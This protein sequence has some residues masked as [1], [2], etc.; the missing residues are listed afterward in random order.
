LGE[1]T[2]VR[3]RRNSVVIDASP[4]GPAWLVLADANYPGWTAT[5]D[6]V[7]AE[8]YMVDHILRG[9]PL[10]AGRH[11][12]VFS[13]LPSGFWAALTVT[14][15]TLAGVLAGLVAPFRSKRYVA[16]TA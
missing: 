4:A 13:Y 6:G 11:R 2:I 14:L 8:I 12:V 7:Q 16:K 10:Q 1:A 9:V 5:V 3:Y 15:L